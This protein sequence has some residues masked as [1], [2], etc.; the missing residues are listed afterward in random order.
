[1]KVKFRLKKNEDFQKVIHDNKKISNQVFVLYFKKNSLDHARIGISTS[2]KLGCAV[3]RNRIRRQ[4]RVMAV[5][6]INLQVNQD[7]ILIVRKKYLENTYQKN[8]EEL[9]RLLS[10][11]KEN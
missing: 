10:K 5:S 4:V 7:Y 1:M 6:L 2:K 9:Q 11:I 8:M 3:V